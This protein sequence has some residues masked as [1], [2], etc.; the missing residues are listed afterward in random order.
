M[1]LHACL[2]VV[3]V[4]LEVTFDPP[5][6]SPS[7]LGT[8]SGLLSCSCPPLDLIIVCCRDKAAS[9]GQDKTR[10]GSNELLSVIFVHIGGHKIGK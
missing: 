2:G 1:A 8:S 10:V 3:V 7:S 4:G 5:R 9:R 6:N